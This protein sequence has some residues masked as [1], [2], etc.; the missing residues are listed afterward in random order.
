MLFDLLD[1]AEELMVEVK[2]VS[3]QGQVRF[4]VKNM[5]TIKRDNKSKVE[6]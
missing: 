6:V 4:L 3:L 1:Y 2:A 5:L